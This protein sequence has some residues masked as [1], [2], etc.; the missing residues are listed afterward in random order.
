MKELNSTKNDVL[1]KISVLSTYI[2]SIHFILTL[3]LAICDWRRQRQRE[4][5]SKSVITRKYMNRLWGTNRKRNKIKM[6]Q[7]AHTTELEVLNTD[8]TQCDIHSHMFGYCVAGKTTLWMQ[9][10]VNQQTERKIHYE[11]SSRIRV[12][13]KHVLAVSW[14][15]LQKLVFHLCFCCRWRCCCFLSFSFVFFIVFVV[16]LMCVLCFIPV[17]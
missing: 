1:K 12:M 14:F 6:K 8:W 2:S 4:C 3:S 11:I 17:L 5:V 16:V 10:A 15:P 9:V 13:C 7:K